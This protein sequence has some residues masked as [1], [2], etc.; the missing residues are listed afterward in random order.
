MVV[1]AVTA[2][3]RARIIESAKRKDEDDAPKRKVMAEQHA[4]MLEQLKRV[5]EERGR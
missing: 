3:E 5:D 4:L 1:G 2:E